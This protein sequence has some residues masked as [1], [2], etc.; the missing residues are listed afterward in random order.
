MLTMRDPRQ[1]D[2]VCPVKCTDGMIF[3][4]KIG[5]YRIMFRLQVKD[6]EHIGFIFLLDSKIDGIQKV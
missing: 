6:G 4:I 1:H 3:R 5:Q 2:A